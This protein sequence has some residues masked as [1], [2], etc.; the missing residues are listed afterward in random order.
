M[1]KLVL[2]PARSRVRIQTFAQGLL[3]RLAHDLELVCRSLTGGAERTST[4]KGSA[5]VEVPIGAI[6]VAGTLK[7]GRVDP[8]GL[9]P[10]DREDCLVKM[11][12]DV[13]HTT[14]GTAAIVRIEATLEAEKA[15]VRLVPPNGRA[16]ERVVPVRLQPEGDAG[17]RVSGR[18][19]VS[20]SAIGSDPVKGPM[21]AFRV[22]DSV[23]VLFELVFDARAAPRIAR[24]S[25]QRRR[26]CRRFALPAPR[27]ARQTP[28]RGLRARL[29]QRAEPSWASPAALAFTLTFGFDFAPTFRFRLVAIRE[30]VPLFTGTDSSSSGASSSTRQPYISAITRAVSRGSTVFALIA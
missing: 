22:K 18:F 19:D 15:R 27:S 1:T 24:R 20:L 11:R 30:R 13:F 25:W 8:N 4:D 5:S 29:G 7:D 12:R 16:L 26:C 23:E 3:A 6:E 17:T 14:S 2:D 28:L 10:S 9:S 21:N